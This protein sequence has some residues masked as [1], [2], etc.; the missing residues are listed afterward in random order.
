M[1]ILKKVRKAQENKKKQ[2]HNTIKANIKLKVCWLC[3]KHFQPFVSKVTKTMINI[4]W[5]NAHDYRF[6]ELSWLAIKQDQA[7]LKK[8]FLTYM[9]VHLW[10]AC[11]FHLFDKGRFLRKQKQPAIDLP[12]N[13]LQ[14]QIDISPHLEKIL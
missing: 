10:F 8:F 12:Y 3:L 6:A 13:S 11:S 14:V 4:Y 1:E 9:Y 7:R 5:I 2:A